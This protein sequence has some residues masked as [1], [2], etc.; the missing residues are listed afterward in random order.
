MPWGGRAK[1]FLGKGSDKKDSDK[2]KN[3]EK[4]TGNDQEKQNETNKDS[5][6]GQVETSGELTGIHLRTVQHDVE[7]VTEPA[8]PKYQEREVN[9]IPVLNLP[10]GDALDGKGNSNGGI[11]SAHGLR[12]ASPLHP[13]KQ[14]LWDEA[15]DSLC[16]KEPDL[17]K[18][19]ERDLLSFQVQEKKGML[20]AIFLTRICI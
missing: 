18:A 13:N 6:S 8:K 9:A 10:P 16:R 2:R 15:Y 5:K 20:S 7:V 4:K 14:R 17:M 12:K 11:E 1:R 19:Y 3:I